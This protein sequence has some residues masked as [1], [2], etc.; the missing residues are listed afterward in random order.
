MPEGRLDTAEPPTVSVVLPVHNG[1]GTIRECVASL[2]AQRYPRDRYEVIVVDNG[3]TDTTLAS[4]VEFGSQIRLL[5]ESRRGAGAARN[6]GIRDAAGAVIAFIDADATADPD[7]LGALV[8]ASGDSAVGAAGGRILSRRPCNRIELFG[9]VIHDQQAAV[10]SDPPY[11]ATGSWASRR[12]VLACVGLFD[13]SLLRGQDA[14]LAWRIHQ[15][16][17]QL[18]YQPEAVVYHRNE[19]TVLGLCREG[20]THGIAAVQVR[21]RHLTPMSGRVRLRSRVG[22]RLLHQVVGLARATDRVEAVLRIVFD[23][24]KLA[25]ELVALGRVSRGDPTASPEN[26]A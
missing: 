26:G 15:A 9:E 4:L 2:L 19:R 13:E 24:G 18:V 12:D 17:Y 6:R 8:G 21:S 25:G 5:E 22:Q 14:D 11:L 20:F 1:A 23:A 7:W 10:R 16:G 3:S